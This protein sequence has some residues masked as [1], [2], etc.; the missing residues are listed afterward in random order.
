MSCGVSQ[1]CNRRNA[2]RRLL[3]SFLLLNANVR[4]ESRFTC[5]RVVAFRRSTCP[6]GNKLECGKPF[7]GENFP[8]YNETISL[9]SLRPVLT[10]AG[11]FQT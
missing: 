3:G 9:T 2:A 10:N 4:R 8:T 1:N 11:N 6:T 5:K 7:I